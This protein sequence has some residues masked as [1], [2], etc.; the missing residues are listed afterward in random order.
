[1]LSTEGEAIELHLRLYTSTAMAVNK[2]LT[3][4]VTVGKA[5]SS[6]ERKFKSDYTHA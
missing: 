3:V 4:N 2:Q 1:M 6:L 5:I